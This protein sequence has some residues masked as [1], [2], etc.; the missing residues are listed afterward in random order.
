MLMKLRKQNAQN[1][2]IR[3]RKQRSAQLDLWSEP[4][5]R[6][7]Q[8]V[9]W[10]DGM[11]LPFLGA[12]LKLCLATRREMAA[13]ENGIL[14]LPLPPAATARQIQDAVEACLRQEAASLISAELAQ[15]AAQA[16]CKPPAWAFSFA[17]QA[18]WV[19]QHGDHSNPAK[20]ALRFNWRIIELP[21][22]ELQRIV[23]Q[24][25]TALAQQQATTDLWG[26]HSS[27]A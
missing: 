9:P 8:A 4:G 21:R 1:A 20:Q 11:A 26:Q 19:Q 17:A 25:V 14:Y 15:A 24:A 7:E 27:T 3:Q 23:A 22:A 16:G 13:I 12:E 6:L 5:N 10:R 2:L 18:D